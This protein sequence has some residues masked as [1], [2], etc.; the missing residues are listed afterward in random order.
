MITPGAELPL[1]TVYVDASFR[2]PRRGGRF[3]WVALSEYRVVEQHRGACR[4]VT[5]STAAELWALAHV[6]SHLRARPPVPGTEILVRCDNQSVVDALDLGSIKAKEL[7]PMLLAALHNMAV[8]EEHGYK[9]SCQWITRDLNS[10]ADAA[11][12]YG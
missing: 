2:G 9:V 7:Q 1:L 11:C 12:R 4:H 5:S 8:L 6:L 3:A 10:L